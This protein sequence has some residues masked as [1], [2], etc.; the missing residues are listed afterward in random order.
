MRLQPFFTQGVGSGLGDNDAGPIGSSSSQITQRKVRAEILAY[1]GPQVTGGLPAYCFKE[2]KLQPSG[3]FTPSDEGPIYASG[4]C[5]TISSYT[6]TGYAYEMNGNQS[7]KLPAGDDPGAYVELTPLGT[8]NVDG[9]EEWGFTWSNVLDD[10]RTATTVLTKACPEFGP[11]TF[12]YDSEIGAIT[13]VLLDG[14]SIRDTS[15]PFLKHLIREKKTLTFPSKLVQESA[16]ECE[17]DVQDCCANPG[18]CCVSEDC[19]TLPRQWQLVTTGITAGLGGVECPCPDLNGTFTLTYTGDGVSGCAWQSEPVP[20]TGTWPP[21]DL[22]EGATGVW[23]LQKT[24]ESADPC[25]WR[26][27]FYL[28]SISTTILSNFPPPP[29][30]EPVPTPCADVACGGETLFDLV[31]EN[32]Y[33]CQ[34]DGIPGVG[35]I[36]PL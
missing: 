32:P 4:A 31:G 35:A 21:C 8:V 14:V 10:S 27:S 16:P 6:K 26:L 24:C 13:D 30:T 33:I 29:S 34:A 3:E 12:V 18:G 23:I 28:P 22:G 9:Q 15:T 5:D 2:V 17:T 11:L 20:F 19:P 25:N 7:V 1:Q 36:T